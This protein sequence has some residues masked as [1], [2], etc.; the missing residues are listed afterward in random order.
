VCNL[1]AGCRRTLPRRDFEGML[2]PRRRLV[3][4]TFVGRRRPGRWEIVEQDCELRGRFSL[5]RLAHPV[6][7]L[8][9]IDPSLRHV[10]LQKSDRLVTI[11]IAD[12][13]FHGSL[14]RVGWLLLRR[15]GGLRLGRG[16]RIHN[17]QYPLGHAW[18]KISRSSQTTRLAAWDRSRC[19]PRSAKVRRLISG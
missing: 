9:S 12:A 2:L 6:V 3:H 15:L 5:E 8:R 13:R 18:T 1:R 17:P 14:C 11:G 7:E 10:L 4:R 16:R 19:G